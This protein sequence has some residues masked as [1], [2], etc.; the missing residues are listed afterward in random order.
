[1]PA[2]R[3]LRREAERAPFA[4]QHGEPAFDTGIGA[5]LPI[6]CAARTKRI[7]CTERTAST[8]RSV[9]HPIT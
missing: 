7:V 9:N 4:A 5:E 3:H 2:R 6:A 8:E 1:M